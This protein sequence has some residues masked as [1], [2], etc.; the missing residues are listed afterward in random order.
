MRI[1]E[2]GHEL[3]QGIRLP[4][5]VGV[6]EGHDLPA[7]SLYGRVLSDDL[8][9]ARELEHEVG[10]SVARMLGSGVRA[11]VAGHDHLE[12][13]ARIV[14]RERIGDLRADHCLLVMRGDDQRHALIWGIGSCLYRHRGFWRWRE[15]AGQRT[16]AKA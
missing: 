16:T 8:A 15:E 7:R 3:A 6:G 1:G 12:Q 13:L 14:Q 11:A 2:R 9:A 10:A 5:G 4:L